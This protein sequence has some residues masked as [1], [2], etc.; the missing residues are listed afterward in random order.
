M[1]KKFVCFCN[2]LQCDVNAIFVYFCV[3]SKKKLVMITL[4][5][6]FESLSGED[7]QAIGDMYIAVPSAES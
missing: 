4:G 6:C 2:L 3:S 1:K 5:N 7:V